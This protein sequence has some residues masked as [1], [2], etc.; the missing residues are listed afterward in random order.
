MHEIFNSIVPN[1]SSIK[2]HFVRQKFPSVNY[3]RDSDGVSKKIKEM[4]IYNLSNVN[5]FSLLALR[6]VIKKSNQLKLDF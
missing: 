3:A 1:V 2:S 6:T 4:E 5:L